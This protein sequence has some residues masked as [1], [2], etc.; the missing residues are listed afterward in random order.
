MTDWALQRNRPLARVW[1]YYLR[2]S[3]V[4]SLLLPRPPALPA[5]SPIDRP[6]LAARLA[7]EYVADRALVQQLGRTYGFKTLFVWQ[8]SVADKPSLSAQERHYAGWLPPTPETTPPVDWWAMD[9]E[10]EY[11]HGEVGRLVKARGV[12]DVSAA[13]DQVTESAFIDWMHTSEAGNERV[14]GE[15]YKAVATPA[16]P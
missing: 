16:G 12:L 9:T 6:A 10:L 13:L 7:D 11:L 5:S 4:W 15:L 8:V 2:T 14:A 1:D 3:Y